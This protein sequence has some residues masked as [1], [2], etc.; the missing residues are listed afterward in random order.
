[1]AASEDGRW[2]PPPDRVDEVRAVALHI[3]D[4]ARP[5]ARTVGYAIG[6][7]GSLERDVDLIAVPWTEDA[8]DELAVVS[9]IQQAITDNLGQCYR[10]HPSQ[11]DEKPHGRRA[12][13]LYFQGAVETENGAYP[14]VD[15]SV[16]PRR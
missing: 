12:W 10:S 13:I 7:H 16:L 8:A 3:L 9:A 5:A 14:F 1:M 2:R 6:L 4:L 15:L 11:V